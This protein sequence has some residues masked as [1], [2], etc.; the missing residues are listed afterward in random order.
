MEPSRLHDMKT[1]VA[2][3]RLWLTVL[4]QSA[5]AADP[6]AVE[7][8]DKLEEGIAML[9]SQATGRALLEEPDPLA[10]TRPLAGISVLVVD[11]EPQMRDGLASV[12]TQLGARATAAATAGAAL[13]A[14]ARERPTVLITD[15]RL[16]ADDGLALLRHI[17]ALPAERGG[18]VPAIALTGSGAAE[19]REASRR[20]GFHRHLVKPPTLSELVA[21]LLELSR[22]EL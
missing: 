10:G 22:G 6:K 3:L 2:A 12:L 1:T 14:L 4:C 11:D 13:E 17:R 20:A 15:V 7:A 18:A 9:V 5:A 19:D 21:S 16:G 8:I